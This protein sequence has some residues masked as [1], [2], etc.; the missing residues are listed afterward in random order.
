MKNGIL[1]TETYL[2][3]G[4]ECS[5]RGMYDKKNIIWEWANKC[6][7][8]K[9][10]FQEYMQE[11]FIDK[12][13]YEGDLEEFVYYYTNKEELDRRVWKSICEGLDI[14]YDSFFDAEIRMD[15]F[16]SVVKTYD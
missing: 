11:K 15:I 7:D 2:Y 4:L 16:S 12:C 8:D 5:N 13:D 6:F 9:D 10:K 14:K 1:K 3:V